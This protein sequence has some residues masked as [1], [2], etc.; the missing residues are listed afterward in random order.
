MEYLDLKTQID[1][2][3]TRIAELKAALANAEQTARVNLAESI[4]QQIAEHGFTLESI[5]SLLQPVK[6]KRAK[7]SENPQR[8]SVVKNVITD[9]ETGKVY[10]KGPLPGW[11]KDRMVNAGLD[12]DNKADRV[13]Y[14]ESLMPMDQA[15]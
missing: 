4:K 8:L 11:L 14:R 7:P 2:E 1:A 10:T 12:P 15:A 3:E 13:K 6:A 5:M 9:P